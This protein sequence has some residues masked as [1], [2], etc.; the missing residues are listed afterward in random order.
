MSTPDDAQVPRIPEMVGATSAPL[1]LRGPQMTVTIPI[2]EPS[3]PASPGAG[4]SARWAPLRV[5]LNFEKILGENGSPPLDVYLNLPPLDE[6]VRHPELLAGEL[7]MFGL[8]EASISDESH[9]PTGLDEQL[10]ITALYAGLVLVHGWN[11]RELRVTFV[12]ELRGQPSSRPDRP[13][14]RV[15]RMSSG[16][17]RRPRQTR[18]RPGS[19]SSRG[20]IPSG[21]WSPC[22]ARR[23]RRWSSERWRHPRHGPPRGGLRA[24]GRGLDADGRGHHAAA[25]RAHRA[26]GRRQQPLGRGVT[27]PPWCSWA[28]SARPGWSWASGSP[29]CARASGPTRAPRPPWR[30]RARP[31]GSARGFT[32]AGSWS[33]TGGSRWRLAAGEPIATACV[34][35]RSWAATAS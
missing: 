7:P 12:F 26:P 25:G 16:L 2:E 19:S 18:A 34:S 11:R 5:F 33:A 15:L 35:A 27:G 13:R 30:S 22:A 10:E 23:G 3:G 32:G 29:R 4:R 21:G 6:P 17:R 20:P 9:T 24:G 8:R 1:V 14:E 31:C 28:G